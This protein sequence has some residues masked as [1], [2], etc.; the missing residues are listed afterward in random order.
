DEKKAMSAMLGKTAE[1]EQAEQKL[2][3][4]TRGVLDRQR[5]KA[6]QLMKDKIDQF[7]KKELEKVQRLQKRAQEVPQDPLAPFDQ[8]E[9]DRARRRIEDLKKTLDQGDLEQATE[10]A[11]KAQCRLKSI[12]DDTGEDG[13]RMPWWKRVLEDRDAA[14]KK[15]GEAEPIAKEVVDDLEKTMPSPQQMMSQEDRK[16]LQ[17]LSGQQ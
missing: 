4:E 10:M 2:R 6:Q 14:Q 3:D 13:G 15:L 5:E 16:R 8:E 12:H 1:L 9:L 11:R 7:V 17:D